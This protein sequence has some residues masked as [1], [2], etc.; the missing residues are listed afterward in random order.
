MRASRSG[1]RLSSARAAALDGTALNKIAI[2]LC[3]ANAEGIYELAKN[4][5]RTRKRSRIIAA[6]IARTR[7]FQAT[8]QATGNEKGS[9]QAG[10]SPNFLRSSLRTIRSRVARRQPLRPTPSAFQQCPYSDPCR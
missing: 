3:C 5:V 8:G 6:D 4:K 9:G 2:A 7:P 1:A 10:L